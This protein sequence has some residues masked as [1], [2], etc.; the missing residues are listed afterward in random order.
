VRALQQAVVHAA[1]A[2]GR[3]GDLPQ[4]PGGVVRWHLARWQVG[5]AVPHRVRD[6]SFESVLHSDLP[7]VRRNPDAASQQAFERARSAAGIPP[8]P[9]GPEASGHL[10]AARLAAT[11][12]AAAVTT[13][14]AARAFDLS[15]IA[16]EDHVVEVWIADRWL[17]HPGIDA[18]GEILTTTA[19]TERVAHFG[20]Y[21]LSHCGERV[22]A[23]VASRGA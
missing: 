16:L 11:L 5:L 7:I 4:P 1:V 2:H 23:R 6:Q 8:L 22:D 9:R 14:G 20:G 15:F 21:D 10:D 18:L 19:F 17:H 13:E 3:P 12:S